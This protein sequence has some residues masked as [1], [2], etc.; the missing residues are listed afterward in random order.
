MGH[1][2]WVV[3]SQ[4]EPGVDDRLTITGAE[5][6]SSLLRR[7]EVLEARTAHEQGIVPLEQLREIE[8][9]AV[10]AALKMQQEAGIDVVTDGEM[11]RG[12][13]SGGITEAMEGI[14][15]DPDAVY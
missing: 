3:N 5:H 4:Q 7:P 2:S 12:W 14:V 8:D 15:D 1:D 10:L 11:R 6:I 9:K 13:W